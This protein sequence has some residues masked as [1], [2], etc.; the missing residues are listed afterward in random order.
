MSLS[1]DPDKVSLPIGHFIGGSLIPAKGVIDMHRPSDGKP[2]AGCP[3]AGEDLVDEAV[4]VAHKALA[5]SRW[6]GVRPRE[7]T[8]VLQAWADLME[9]EGETLARIEAISSTRP[10]SQLMSGDIPVVAEQ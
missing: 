5:S 9:V 7:R 4:S 6:A 8:K 2:H 1:F 10:I 3:I